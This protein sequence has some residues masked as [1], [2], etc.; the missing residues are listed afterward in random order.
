MGLVESLK[1]IYDSIEEA[2]YGFAEG[3]QS[4]GIPFMDFFVT[5]IESRGVPSLPVF[6]LLFVGLAAGGLLVLTSQDGG[7]GTRSLSITVQSGGQ[8]ID[9]A[10]V[11]VL[12]GDSVLAKGVTKGGKITFEG[13]PNS[14]LTVR[15]SKPGYKTLTLKA[16]ARQGT[17]KAEL[18][19]TPPGTED[20]DPGSIDYSQL[21]VVVL[22]ADTEQPLAEAQV[23]YVS[24][25]GSGQKATD[26]QGQVVIPKSTLTNLRVS[27]AGYK[28]ETLTVKDGG[29]TTV[30]LKPLSGSFFGGGEEPIFGGNGGGNGGGS[31][32]GN[33]D[34]YPDDC[35]GLN[36]T[37]MGVVTIQLNAS[38][39]PV[40]GRV[41]LYGTDGTLFG[42]SDTISGLAAFS[43]PV[44]SQ[45]FVMA[46]VAGFTLYDGSAR[47]QAVT[48]NT[49]FLIQ[50]DGPGSGNGLDTVIRAQD[51]QGNALTFSARIIKPPLLEL[52]QYSGE[53]WEFQAQP[54][55]YYVFVD[56]DGYLSKS[57][58]L[59][60]G[61]DNAFTL[62]KATPFN[63]GALTVNVQ[64]EYGAAL[65]GVRVTLL[66]SDRLAAT[67]QETDYSGSVVFGELALA[68]YDVRAQSGSRN[69]TSRVTIEQGGSQVFLNLTIHRASL[70]VKSLT[71]LDQSALASASVRIESL[72]QV[73]AEVATDENGSAR[74]A[75]LPAQKETRVS[76]SKTS[77]VPFVADVVFLDGESR[78]LPAVLI[79]QDATQGAKVDLVQ[80]R[81]LDG[82]RVN[83]LKTGGMYVVE[84]NA[85]PAAAA[86]NQS[87]YFRVGSQSDVESDDAYIAEYTGA[88][89]VLRSTTY[90]PSADCADLAAD[91]VSSAE[92]YKWVELRFTQPA[93]RVAS[94]LLQVKPNARSNQKLSLYFAT[95]TEN[96]SLAA[97]DPPKAPAAPCYPETYKYDVP[98]VKGAT[99]SVSPTP[100]PSGTPQPT[101]LPTSGGF[102]PSVSIRYNPATGKVET[103][104][105]E[106][107]LQADAIYPRDT[108]PL[109]ITQDASCAIEARLEAAT[110]DCFALSRTELTFQS[111]EYAGGCPAKVKGNQLDAPQGEANL[112]LG[113][114]CNPT[115]QIMIPIR[116]N[117]Q[118][119]TSITT[120]PGQLDEG[121]GTAKLLYVINQKQSGA[122][123]LTPLGASG[124]VAV[125]AHA[126]TVF[127]WSGPGTL[128]LLDGDVNVGEW[129]YQNAPAYFDG[130][131]SMGLRIESASDYL[132]CA[133]GWCS[134]QAALQ[135]LRAFQ[136]A[137]KETAAATMF[138]RG[139]STTL[140]PAQ[141]TP[142]PTAVPS[143]TPT[144]SPTPS[145]SPSASPSATASATASVTPTPTPSPSPSAQATST[146]VTLKVNDVKVAANGNKIKLTEILDAS[147]KTYAGFS[148]LSSSG[149]VLDAPSFEAG[150]AAYNK[151]GL[152]FQ[153]TSID[154][155]SA[156]SARAVHVQLIGSWQLSSPSSIGLDG[157]LASIETDAAPRTLYFAAT[158]GEP[159]VFSTVMQLT[160]GA[161]KAFDI[162]GVQRTGAGCGGLPGVWLVTATSTDGN[163]FT[164]S[165][166]AMKLQQSLDGRA[167]DLL[168]CGFLHAQKKQVVASK[169]PTLPSQLQASEEHT[170]PQTKIAIFSLAPVYKQQCEAL[171][172]QVVTLK[173]ELQGLLVD[174]KTASKIL[175]GLSKATS[176]ST[177]STARLSALEFLTSSPSG[178]GSTPYSGG[179]ADSSSGPVS[180]AGVTCSSS[181]SPKDFPGCKS[182]AKAAESISSAAESA[183]ACPAAAS[184]N[185]AASELDGK[186]AGAIDVAQQ[187]LKVALDSSKITD[188]DWVPTPTPGAS[189]SA[190]A[191]VGKMEATNAA[192]KLVEAVGKFAP[193]VVTACGAAEAAKAQTPNSVSQT[194]CTPPT[195][196]L[197]AGANALAASNA[198]GAVADLTGSAM[199][200]KLTLERVRKEYESK[201]QQLTA[202]KQ[203][204]DSM[205]PP[206]FE[207]PFGLWPQQ[208]QFA[209]PS[210][211]QYKQKAAQLLSK[212]E[213]LTLERNDNAGYSQGDDAYPQ[214]LIDGYNDD[215]ADAQKQANDA[216]ALAG[217]GCIA[218]C[219]PKPACI[220]SF[221]M[222]RQ[223]TQVIH[224]GLSS[225]CQPFSKSAAQDLAKS[226]VSNAV[227]KAL[228]PYAMMASFSTGGAC[229]GA[230][231][232][233]TTNNLGG[234]GGG[235]PTSGG[236]GGYIG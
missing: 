67:D 73:L 161:D 115:S 164:Y 177:V 3:L 81:Q 209:C 125:G 41:R 229:Q 114:I 62:E 233:F 141:P 191:P 225:D 65:S 174:M 86:T 36:L 51:A 54:G 5:P 172:K 112:V 48:E 49:I 44:G 56:S 75:E 31:G 170:K 235:I 210:E 218:V 180:G 53:R 128:S 147:G 133:Q 188:K 110:P 153:V 103:D 34:E 184:G 212:V 206:L 96:G 217:K 82:Q 214:E 186:L 58:D 33:C 47:P 117:T 168:L 151:N 57:A 122:R 66:K 194:G 38:S 165:A 142:I 90:N 193:S 138:R 63:S 195:A 234:Q 24:D 17:L 98:L 71:A 93:S 171:G 6:L 40:D 50:L 136:T 9:G 79:P 152:Q 224:L 146:S 135:A 208:S 130:I 201:K 196:I 21:T 35:N 203:K 101:V 197:V 52:A 132:G 27:K 16:S 76:V 87:L 154:P 104:V 179:I 100:T 2:Y 127:S 74:F 232:Y 26:T 129:T 221:P 55:S 29:L 149:T 220:E 77:F 13:L 187:S 205:S 231:G 28:T 126:A 43:A 102:T 145:A 61:K 120:A 15:V 14:A 68:A 198:M 109:T 97:R 157:I 32:G 134:G 124:A 22:D 236:G 42:E 175:E 108:V 4:K 83:Q 60:V 46:Q 7:G 156:G 183:S 18:K 140:P 84:L 185:K 95:R 223:F 99:P 213:K 91:L 105:T 173:Q 106:I 123:T 85:T 199:N 190:S 10:N 23:L 222:G 20:V 1:G 116:V 181:C 178:S 70:N 69:A 207:I 166:H 137:A 39:G 144:P 118:T 211:D 131:G 227:M 25:E 169:N 159:F 72:G 12:L 204:C 189:G 45:V 167:Q 78:T 163:S 8:M 155:A 216:L 162:L 215:I 30:F 88:D 119:A 148:V 19:S 143:T 230:Q 139:A 228:G 158:G 11:Q 107:T 121:E 64:D 113:A 59:L 200:A 182:L 80:I 202:T 150:E 176:S 94:F 226:M 219:K 160:E 37:E 92:G 111:N 89:S 192:N